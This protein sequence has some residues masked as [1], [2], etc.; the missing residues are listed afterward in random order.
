MSDTNGGDD[1]DPAEIQITLVEPVFDLALT[2]VLTSTGPFAPGDIISFEITVFNQG[3]VDASNTIVT[4]YS[5][6]GLIYQS[7]TS[8]ANVIDNGNETFTITNIPALSSQV[9]EVFYQIDPATTATSM[10]NDAEITSDSGDDVDSMPGDDSTPDDTTN[11]NDTT[12]TNGGDDQD[13]S[14][15]IIT[16]PELVF[17]LALTKILTSTGPLAPGDIVSFEITLFNQ[18]EVDAT[19]T[20]V[21][22]DSP[23]GLIYQ[24]STSDANVIDNGN[25]TFL[26]LNLAPM[27]SQVIEVF[28]QIDPTF[29][30]ASLVNDAEITIDSGDDIDSTPGDDGTPDDVANDNDIADM[31]GGDDQDPATV[32]VTQLNPIFDLALTK[33][34]TM[35]GPFVPGDIISFDITVHNQG[36]VDASNTVVTDDSPAGLI[37][38]S[39]TADAN[40]V[41]NGDETFTVLNL[42]AMSSQVITVFYQIDPAT[43]ATSMINDAEITSDSGDDID[44]TTGDDATPDDTANDND[45]AD[46]NGGDDQD[47]AEVIIIQANPIFDLALTKNVTSAGPFAPGD[48]VS[49]EIT[50]FNQG[51]VDAVNTVVTDYSPAGLNYQSST[52]DANVVDNGDETFTIL[53]LSSM[54]SQVFEVIYQIDPA[55]TATSMINDAEITSDSGDDVDTTTGDDSTPD[56]TFNDND[57]ADTTGGDDQD[58]AEIVITQTTSI[59]DLA[60]TKELT[61]AGPFVPGDVVSFEIT[62]HNQRNVDASNTVVTDDSPTGLIYQSSTAD[63]NVV[64]N[65]DETFTVL[66][67]PSL[68]SQVIEV[69]YQIDPATTAT[70]MINDAEI[71]ADSGDDIDSTCLLYTSPSPRDQRGSRMPSS[72]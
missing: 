48:L 51:D 67:V 39:S 1:Q 7:T 14:E 66:N 42:P 18:G 34:L 49:F 57:I 63:A 22:D 17:D 58:P 64:D 52:F 62:V 59:F 11:N 4:D 28:Y 13:P 15:V 45:I 16:Q 46:A 21:T 24:S 32:Q 40:V 20:M 27:T 33:E 37:Y 53:N 56:D 6:P 29:T 31:N 8:D 68:T 41:D 35:A 55:T 47:P 30:G 12:D 71:T 36:D 43:T 10:I 44:S 69:F 61:S 38:Q 9:I 54:T 65:G 70:S 3:E 50:V 60:L 72:A 2:K 23:A 19:G 26:V 5:P 25:E